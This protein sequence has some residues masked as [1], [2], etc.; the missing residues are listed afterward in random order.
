MKPFAMLDPLGLYILAFGIAGV[1]S[2]LYTLLPNGWAPGGR[3]HHVTAIDR[4]GDVLAITLEPQ[5]RGIKHR[6][7]QFAFVQFAL[8]GREEVHPF[9]ISKEPNESG[10]LRFTVK[11]LCD[12]TCALERALTVGTRA[13]VSGPFGRFFL[14][15]DATGEIWTAGGIGVTPFVAQAQA[16]EPDH[17]PVHLFLCT[18]GADRA[19]H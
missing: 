4:S 6:P 9:T 18:R 19:A 16:L 2:Y 13:L 8:L 12:Y 14:Q 7:G 3:D 1:L 11:G 10:R 17:P 5:H 15:R